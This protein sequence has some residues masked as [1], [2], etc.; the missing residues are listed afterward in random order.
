MV[1]SVFGNDKEIG[2]FCFF[3]RLHP[4]FCTLVVLAAVETGVLLRDK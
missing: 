4:V 2:L 3:F 1:S